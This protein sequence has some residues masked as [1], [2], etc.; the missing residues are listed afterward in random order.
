MAKAF[1]TVLA[2]GPHPPAKTS[3]AS[4][5]VVFAGESI[6]VVA[7][8]LALNAVLGHV[9]VPKGAEVLYVM[10]D[11]TDL[12]TNGA[13]TITLSIGDA[14]DDD[15]LLAANNAGQT[16]AA[17]VGPTIAKTGFGHRYEEETLVQVKVKAAAATAAATGTIKYGVAYVSQ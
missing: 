7:A 1:E 13:P 17:P 9:R 5:A 15:R 4:N 3:T 6:D 12:D 11:A 16:G 10:L 14:E 8:D 2:G